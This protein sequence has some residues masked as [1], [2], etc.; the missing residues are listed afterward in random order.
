MLHVTRHKTLES[1]GAAQLVLPPILFDNLT[2]YISKLRK[3]LPCFSADMDTDESPIFLN[4]SGIGLS[5]SEIG[6]L[7]TKELRDCGIKAE[8][9]SCR[10]IRK[11]AV[12]H[13]SICVHIGIH[14]CILFTFFWFGVIIV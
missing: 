11:A 7:L 12:T 13:V 4:Y 2:T 6:N 1:H 3:E 5:H 8:R 14:L 10:I 9:I